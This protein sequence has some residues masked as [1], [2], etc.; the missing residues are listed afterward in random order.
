MS[1]QSLRIQDSGSGSGYS[2]SGIVSYF[3]LWN[4]D[5]SVPSIST[6]VVIVVVDLFGLPR[7]DVT[8][9]SDK[10]TERI[11]PEDGLGWHDNREHRRRC[12]GLRN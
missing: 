10:A 8:V 4:L 12:G 3:S 2:A 5:V 11:P 6:N 9:L 7:E 1:P